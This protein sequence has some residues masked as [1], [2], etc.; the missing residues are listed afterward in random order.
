MEDAEATSHGPIT[1]AGWIPGDSEA[2]AENIGDGTVKGV[3]VLDHGAICD[4][5]LDGLSR[6]KE[7][8]RKGRKRAA[9]PGIAEII[10]SHAVIDRKSVG[11]FPSIFSKETPGS[12]CG[13]PVPKHGLAG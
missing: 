1:V 5:L 11:S 4:L 10:P 6:S 2:R 12:I 13:I 7:E 8:V 9:R 3:L